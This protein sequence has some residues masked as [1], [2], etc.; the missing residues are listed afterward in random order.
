MKDKH[1]APL[2]LVELTTVFGQECNVPYNKE[3]VSLFEADKYIEERVKNHIYKE[4]VKTG[5]HI[6]MTAAEIKLFIQAKYNEYERANS[7]LNMLW[8][9]TNNW[10]KKKDIFSFE[11][12]IVD[13]IL[14]TADS[15]VPKAVTDKLVGKAVYLDL[16]DNGKQ[17]NCKGVDVAGIMVSV[18][19]EKAV[20]IEEGC[21]SMTLCIVG[22]KHHT[23]C[24]VM[25]LSKITGTINEAL[26]T[27]FNDNTKV[28][29]RELRELVSLT[30]KLL[31]YT[32]SNDADIIE[33]AEQKQIYK[34]SLEIKDK[35]REI[36]KWDV[37]TKY[38]AESG[39]PHWEFEK[40][41]EGNYSGIFKWVG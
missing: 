6:R 26:D 14:S 4:L 8:H 35:F 27:V 38:I 16:S 1:C 37:G 40:D 20:G 25:N 22:G 15:V 33:N 39:T 3:I 34:P 30:L 32:I 18:N 17:F 7:S 41:S 23:R 2:Q 10:R 19:M 13:R 5:Q 9:I 21:G 11:R 24:L 28:D 31:L 36:R 29:Y 12:G